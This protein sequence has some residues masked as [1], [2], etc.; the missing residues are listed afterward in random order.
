MLIAQEWSSAFES[1][2]TSPGVVAKLMGLS[3]LP[4]QQKVQTPKRKLQEIDTHDYLNRSPQDYWLLKE[5]SCNHQMNYRS[6]CCMHEKCK[7]LYK[8]KQHLSSN[9]QAKNHYLQHEDRHDNLMD[10]RMALVHEKFIIAKRLATNKK[11]IQSKEFKD[12]LEVFSSNRDL[13]L[14]FLE[15]P[16]S[17]ISKQ[18]KEIQQIISLGS[19]TKRINVLKP[20]TSFD[21]DHDKSMS[22]DRCAC[23]EEIKRNID[24]H[25]WS[26]SL[27]IPKAETR[28][29][30]TRIVVL[31]PS[32]T[33]IHE[34]KANMASNVAVS[35]QESRHRSRNLR[36]DDD[37][38]SR[39]L[40]M[41]ITRQIQK[42]MK[43]MQKDE[44]PSTVFSSTLYLA[45]DSKLMMLEN[46]CREER[47]SNYSDSELVTPTSPNSY[48][49]VKSIN[50]TTVTSCSNQSYSAESIQRQEAKKRLSERWE[51]ATSS[52][53]SHEQ[54]DVKKISSTLG[55]ILANPEVKKEEEVVDRLA[56][57]PWVS[58]GQ[59]Q[60]T[61]I[62]G[63]C[64]PTTWMQESSEDCLKNITRLKTLPAS[65]CQK[66]ICENDEISCTS[67]SKSILLE[68]SSNLKKGK[69]FKEKVSS[70]FFSRMKKLVKDKPKLYTSVSSDVSFH[71]ASYSSIKDSRLSKS[72]H[73]GISVEDT[74]KT[75]EEDV[76]QVS[77]PP[78][79]VHCTE[80]HGKGIRSIEKVWKS[81][82]SRENFS[83]HS[84]ISVL[85]RP[86]QEEFSI[87]FS[88]SS[89]HAI[90]DRT[91]TLSR[92]P[93]IG[94]VSRSTYSE[95][96]HSATLAAPNSLKL[97]KLFSKE[98]KEEEQLGFIHKLISSSN[99][100]NESSTTV[101]AKSH[102]LDCPL[103][104]ILL[105]NLLEREGEETKYRE[106]RSNQK[107]LFDYVSF[108]LKEIGYSS[109]VNAYPWNTTTTM[110]RMK[111]NP[112]VTDA[113]LCRVKDCF[114]E[115]EICT[116]AENNKQFVDYLVK[117]EVIRSGLAEPIWLEMDDF[118]KEIGEKMLDELFDDALAD[119]IGCC[120]S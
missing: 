70:L 116:S 50:P 9:G 41:E 39:E 96:A 16:N 22:K 65:E 80:R 46:D 107:L 95:N 69:S 61:R 55:D 110:A 1:K 97:S 91:E 115:E 99:L 88:H 71:S 111:T 27:S 58:S 26:S 86:F 57:S 75:L 76:F 5:C 37:I 81:E 79:S 38:R 30:P 100:A 44:Y 90:T 93:L 64:L 28:S 114:S 32:P 40:A 7:D 17:L 11:F 15:E 87:S 19:Q 92:S 112:T 101:L 35:A 84:P 25:G 62:A 83:Q 68:E 118:G 4:I 21:S 67:S 53:N 109:L 13:F 117:K 45:D 102:S 51:I 36:T 78:V 104:P 73:D 59:V 89:Q 33:A 66:K 103:N 43:S 52:E 18:L 105:D 74:S 113:V 49:H 14:R 60:D 8:V 48:A 56:I 31:K 20:T 3:K 54:A 98:D 10:K 12:A 24:V 119:L 72:S 6:E 82:I 23:G 29:Q 120:L 63:T 47:G 94:S 106:K 34:T 2:E 85:E 42:D 77:S 108:S